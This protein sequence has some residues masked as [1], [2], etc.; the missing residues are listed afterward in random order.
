MVGTLGSEALTKAWTA[1]AAYIGNTGE[2]A[3]DT[4]SFIV[5]DTEFDGAAW[6][7]FSVVLLGDA[8]HNSAAANLFSHLC[9]SLVYTD[10]RHVCTAGTTGE[11]QCFADSPGLA[12]MAL[13][14]SS[15]ND[16]PG[17][18]RVPR[19][20]LLL[21]MGAHDEAGID[22]IVQWVRWVWSTGY[23]P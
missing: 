4:T 9:T 2:V 7:G 5:R 13:G 20:G 11:E 21:V 6:R 8:R 15:K 22:N 19:S 10:K 3:A 16:V 23:G 17:T 1:A 12:Y 18:A 14:R